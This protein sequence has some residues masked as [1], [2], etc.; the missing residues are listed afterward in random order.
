MKITNLLL[1]EFTVP[2]TLTN[3]FY[4]TKSIILNCANTIKRPENNDWDTE[5]NN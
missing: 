3:K 1:T 5:V 4:L 2:I